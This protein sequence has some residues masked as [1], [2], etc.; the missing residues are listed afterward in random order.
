M[1][2][3]RR[4]LALGGLTLLG[5]QAVSG[6]AWADAPAAVRGVLV[7]ESG[8]ASRVTVALDRLAEARTFFLSAPDRFVIDLANSRLALAGRGEG[9]GAGVVRRYRYAQRPDG[10]SR[11]VLDLEAPASVV[12]QELGSRRAPE[13]SFDI[14]PNA[15]MAVAASAARRETNGRNARRRT[16]V[17]DPGHGGRDPG[18]IG[19]T[20]VREK[21][22]VLDAALKLRDALESR[23]RYHVLLTR[24]AD[25]YV[26]HADRV[27]YARAQHADLFISIHADSNSNREAAGASVYTL[28]ERGAA[29]AQGMM[30]SQNWDVDLGDAPRNGVV[31]DILVDLT[32]RETTNRSA[33]FAQTVI[34]QLRQVAPLLRNTHRNAGY[35]VLLAPDVPAVL[36]ETGFLSNVADERRLSQPREREAMAEAMARAVDTY[37]IGPQMYAARA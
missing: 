2:V 1:D 32:Q 4:H 14:A 37:F 34:P 35:F 18:A 36:I 30:A 15:P 19:V 10:I 29:R 16:I 13:L 25:R 28:S 21:D 24:D 8:A 3:T 12:R 5:A 26:E 33:Q 6:R 11:L 22:V 23:G 7:Q 27:Q 17:I 20:G 31:G 9:P